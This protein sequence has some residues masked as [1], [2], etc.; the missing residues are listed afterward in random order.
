[1]AGYERVKSSVFNLRLNTDSDEG[2]EIRGGK[3]F[4]MRAAA[5]G[6]AVFN[7]RVLRSRN[8][9]IE[10]AVENHHQQLD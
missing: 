4:Q 10:A 3:L 1:M 9:K 8:D 6:N 2:G 5:T 7:R